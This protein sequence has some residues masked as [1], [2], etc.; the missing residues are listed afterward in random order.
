MSIIGCRNEARTGIKRSAEEASLHDNESSGRDDHPQQTFSDRVILPMNLIIGLILP[1]VK[2]RS[3]WNNLCVA[4]KVLR[5]AG[6]SMTPPW[7]ETTLELVEN[8]AMVIKFSPCGHYLALARVRGARSS[9]FVQILDRRNGQQTRLWAIDDEDIL[10]L[11]FS[12]DGKYLASGGTDRS[13]RIWPTDT[14]TKRPTLQ[15]SKTLQHHQQKLQCLAFASDSNILASGSDG[16][17]KIWNVEDEDCQHT[18]DHQHGSPSSLVFSGVG[19]SIQ[20]LAATTDGSLIRIR[21][22]SSHSEFTSDVVVD[23]ATRFLNSV[24]SHCGSFLATIDLM[25]KLC[26]YEVESG[27]GGMSLRRSVTLPSYCILKTN[28]GMAFSPDS[29]MLAVIS[30]Q[31][32]SVVRL[33][34]VKDLTLQRQLK[35]QLR[36]FFPVSLAVDPSNRYLATACSDGRVRLW[37]V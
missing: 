28:A 2:D 13:I 34:D 15:S 7:P 33:F 32:E 26:L 17:I 12:D 3:T 4:N 30:Q 10:C 18:V 35:W 16:E 1:C 25:N 27:E 14:D 22:N 6:R 5:K 24:F 29:K 19:E 23:G 37:T 8:L 9:S 31:G 20:C 36:G 11:A 21:W